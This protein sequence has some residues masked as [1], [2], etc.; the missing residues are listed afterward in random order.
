MKRT[1]K[2]CTLIIVLLI[3]LVPVGGYGYYEIVYRRPVATDNAWGLWI[4]CLKGFEGTVQ[5]IGDE[6]DY[7]YFVTGSDYT[8]RY[9]RPIKD[10]KLPRH[11]PRDSSAPYRVTIEMVPQ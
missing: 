2:T 11:F 6:G 8:P 4:A 1:S 7:S 9:K 3:I 5:Y 10:T